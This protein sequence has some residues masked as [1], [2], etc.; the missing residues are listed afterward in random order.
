METRLDEF[1]AQ[2]ATPEPTPEPPPAVEAPPEAPA[3][4]EA[5]GEPSAPPAPELPPRGEDGKWVKREQSAHM[6]PLEALLAERERR[7]AAERAAEE[8]AKEP[9]PDFWEN[10][11]AALRARDDELRKTLLSEADTRAETKARELF[12]RHTEAA[13]RSRYT[14]YDQVRSVFEEEAQRNPVMA[15]QLRDAADPA[16]FIYRQG[17]TA[18][19]LREVGG[20]LSAYRKRIEADVR[21]KVER[22]MAEKL[23]RQGNAPQ[24][25]NTEPS[26]GAG[27]SGAAWAGPTPLEDILPTR[28]T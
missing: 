13:A 19:E 12:F 15:A 18:T 4:V 14:D 11:E 1:F 10:P 9:K 7:Q 2:T 3:P 17:K 23:S 21:A 28:R 16:E 27:I 25:L 20:D 6:V 24:S 26:K 22:E 8:R 5:K